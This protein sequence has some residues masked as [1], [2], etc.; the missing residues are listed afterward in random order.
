MVL[1]HE[2]AQ[3]FVVDFAFS[4]GDFEELRVDALEAFVGEVETEFGEA[5]LEAVATGA[6][7]ENDFRLFGTDELGGDDFVGAALFE[8]AILVDAATV[9]VGIRADDGL[10]SLDNHAAQLGNHARDRE[11]TVGFHT[12]FAAEHIFADEESHDDLFER[13]ISGALADA[14]DGDFDLACSAQNSGEG[15]C[16][17]HSKV[18]MAVAGKDGFVAV[19]DVLDD[20]LDQF[21]IL[22]GVGVAGGI[23]DVDGGCAGSD[24]GFDDLVDI[25]A[26]GAA[27]VFHKILDVVGVFSGVF[28]CVDA[29]FESLLAGHAKFVLK[30]VL[31]DAQAGV[32]A[33]VFG[34]FEGFAGHVDIFFAGT[35]EATDLNA[36][37]FAGQG[38][39]GFEVTRGGDGESGLDDVDAELDEGVSDFEFLGHGQ[40]DAGALLAIAK[41]GIKNENS[42]HFLPHCGK[43]ASI[44]TDGAV[45][46]G[47]GAGR[48]SAW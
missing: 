27:G 39:D 37:E 1:R 18:V 2:L 36:F 13:G 30:V 28:D 12:G 48:S 31:A 43:R 33:G 8:D 11:E 15:V 9:G 21:A 14:V 4:V 29:D 32:N 17:G 20:A 47:F 19:R 23:G 6:R 46:Y 45:S 44:M 34:V 35:G 3:I 26:V 24:D 5:V 40:A 25:V 10:V 16:G 38:L 42:V 22:F 41:G 7:G